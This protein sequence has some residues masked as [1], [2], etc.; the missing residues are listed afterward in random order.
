MT[1]AFRNATASAMLSVVM[2]TY[3]ADLMPNMEL[4]ASRH[5]YFRYK[6]C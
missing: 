4:L 5:L 3:Y 1:H 6:I 2:A